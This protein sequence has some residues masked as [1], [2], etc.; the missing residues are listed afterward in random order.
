MK[1]VHRD[2]RT[3]AHNW[4]HRLTPDGGTPSR[5]G[6]GGN[7]KLYFDDH[8]TMW[9]YGGH[10]CAAMRLNEEV[11]V[12]NRDRYSNT[13]AAV[14][15]DI[16]NACRH[17]KVI[18]VYYPN[19]PEKAQRL[20]EIKLRELERVASTARPG[21]RRPMLLVE[22][23]KIIDD[24]NVYAS[25]IGEPLLS[26]HEPTAAELAEIA[27]GQ[28]QLAAREKKQRAERE[29]LVAEENAERIQAWLR[30]EVN[31]C[32]YG[33]PMM[34]RLNGEYV[35]TSEGARVTVRAAKRL[36][37][38]VEDCRARSAELVGLDMEISGFPLKVIRAD[39]SV[40]IGCHD[41]PYDQLAKIARQL[42]LSTTVEEVAA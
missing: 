37:T 29:A 14:V 26:Q 4:V 25:L 7:R 18:R 33:S 35:E 10:Y 23:Q 5:G 42:G 3:V 9:S 34:L 24:Y 15:S 30:N 39:G 38:A 32:P 31:H 6:S 20:T 28:R 12:V 2:P 16:V 19:L 11:V 22:R 13:T 27:R 17:L 41:I 8:Q 21:G 40:V 1:K 36:W